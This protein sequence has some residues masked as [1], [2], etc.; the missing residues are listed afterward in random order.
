[1]PITPS[2]WGVRRAGSPPLPR[3]VLA[4]ALPEA[5]EARSLTVTPEGGPALE[6]LPPAK[7]F[8]AP[9]VTDPA[10]LKDSWMAVSV[11][12]LLTLPEALDLFPVHL[13]YF[14]GSTAS[15]FRFIYRA[16]TPRTATLAV[17]VRTIT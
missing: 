16:K 1:M 9:L 5:T 7:L 12:G 14:F 15:R 3:T 2:C 13:R 8:R 11:T 4:A 10:T 6:P 17:T